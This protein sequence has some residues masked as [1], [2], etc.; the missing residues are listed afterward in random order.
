MSLNVSD[1]A[2]NEAYEDVRD[3]KT[4]TNWVFFD[5]ADGRPDRLQVAGSGN[6]GLNE[7]VS[8]LK[9]EVAGWGYVRMNLSNDE[10]SQRIKFVLIPWCGEKVGIMRKAKL[11][12]QIADVKNI[13]RNFHIEV[14]ANHTQ[15]LSEDEILTRLRRA[16]GANYDRQTKPNLEFKESVQEFLNSIKET[17]TA[18][19]Y[20]C[21][22][23]MT[24]FFYLEQDQ[25]QELKFLLDNILR[26][27]KISVK[28]PPLVNLNPL[29]VKKQDHLLL[30]V[31]NTDDYKNA[32]SSLAEK[33]KEI[34]TLRLKRMDHISL[35]Y[36][37]EPNATPKQ[38]MQWKVSMDQGIFDKIKQEADIYFQQVDSPV[39][40]DVVLYERVSK[41]LLVGQAHIFKELD[42]W[43]TH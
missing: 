39:H 11:S 3:D 8:Q 33:C 30:Q 37:D 31:T 14:P 24:G 15:E 9:P 22:I 4:E 16:G 34:V 12:I 13:L 6:G 38:Q 42:R 36:W 19:K 35:A 23:S 1:P 5:F 27:F 2:I 17:T 20:G 29:L 41:G 25:D 40:W 28:V 7:F 18:I 10:Y 21:H 32:I 43:Q 26:N